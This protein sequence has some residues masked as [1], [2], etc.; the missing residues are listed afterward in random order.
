MLFL[1]ASALEP[2]PFFLAMHDLRRPPKSFQKGA[3]RSFV[4]APP[5]TAKELALSVVV[6]L[7]GRDPLRAIRRD[8]IH[9]KTAFCFADILT[10]VLPV[11]R[12]VT[13]ILVGKSFSPTPTRQTPPRSVQSKACLQVRAVK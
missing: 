3:H 8:E 2:D 6:Q 1:S 9:V 4:L 11:A 5:Q 13:E 12:A 10:E 7:V